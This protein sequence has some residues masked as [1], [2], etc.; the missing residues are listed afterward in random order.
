M[1]MEARIDPTPTNSSPELFGFAIALFTQKTGLNY[2]GGVW[3]PQ[4]KTA[5]ETTKD[6]TRTIYKGKLL[7]VGQDPLK[8]IK[9]VIRYFQL[10]LP[11]LSMVN[12]HWRTEALRKIV[13]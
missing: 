11:R 13:L 9:G 10:A 1:A 4:L 7:D 3:E 2:N 6:C 8:L 5:Q 12:F